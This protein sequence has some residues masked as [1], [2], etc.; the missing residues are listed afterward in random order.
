MVIGHEPR[1]IKTALCAVLILRR[2]KP[3]NIYTGEDLKWLSEAEPRKGA[4]F[5]IVTTLREPLPWRIKMSCHSLLLWS[6]RM[7]RGT[8]GA[9]HFNSSMV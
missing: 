2:F 7:R 5:Q 3:M 6:E 4:L 9:T 1:R 8:K